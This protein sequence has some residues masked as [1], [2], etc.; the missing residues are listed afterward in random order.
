MFSSSSVSHVYSFTASSLPSRI[1]LP[2]GSGQLARVLPL[3]WFVVLVLYHIRTCG[4]SSPVCYSG[5]TPWYISIVHGIEKLDTLAESMESRKHCPRIL[6]H[7]R[8]VHHLFREWKKKA[9]KPAKLAGP[10]PS[11]QPF[12]ETVIGS[13]RF[14]IGA[15]LTGWVLQII[16][17]S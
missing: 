6:V 8:F 13:A 14:R 2:Y 9:T 10:S 5:I 4:M 3:V 1:L 12:S 17:S 16:Q 11:L 7:T 15:P